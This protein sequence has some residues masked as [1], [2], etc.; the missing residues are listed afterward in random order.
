[1]TVWRW[2]FK[3][4]LYIPKAQRARDSTRERYVDN[5]QEEGSVADK[6]CSEEQRQALR[7]HVDRQKVSLASDFLS[8]GQSKKEPSAASSAAVKPSPAKMVALERELPK[9]GMVMQKDMKSIRAD[10]EKALVLAKRAENAILETKLPLTD[11]PSAIY[12]GTLQFR[13]QL[14]LRWKGDQDTVVMLGTPRPARPKLQVTG[15][16]FEP[17][18]GCNLKPDFVAV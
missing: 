14:A 5:V 7:D 11:K 3:E 17:F 4:Q 8:H 12:K 9:F 13:Y 18:V 10:V 2:C 16:S 1:M 15:S 6:K